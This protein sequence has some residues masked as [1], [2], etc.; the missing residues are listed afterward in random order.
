[1]LP[2]HINRVYTSYTFM[3]IYIYI[4][5]NISNLQFFIANSHK[6]RFKVCFLPQRIK[7]RDRLYNCTVLF[8]VHLF[9]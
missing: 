4:F 6:R 5:K 9:D 3:Y 1:M 2:L 8:T 7:I